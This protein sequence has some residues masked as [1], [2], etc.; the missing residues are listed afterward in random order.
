[1]LSWSTLNPEVIAEFRANGGRVARFGELPVAI[2]HTI[3]AKSGTLRE[4]PLIVVHD[5]DETLIFGTNAGAR[6]HPVWYFNLR[7]HPRITV[8]LGSDRFVAD[9]VELSERDA[10]ERV[11]I[12]AESTPE[13][14]GYL[15]SASP[16]VIPVFSIIRA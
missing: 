7:A 1:M 5:G 9:V 13:F 2:L 10:A 16:R 11:R 15:E 4:V 3:G 14:S 6:T 12:Q 8:E